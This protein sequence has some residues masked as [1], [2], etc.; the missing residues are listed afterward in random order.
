M[1]ATRWV[2]VVLLSRFEGR[3][4]VLLSRRVVLLS[5]SKLKKSLC[6]RHKYAVSVP[7]TRIL[8]YQRLTRS[9]QK[10]TDRSAARSWPASSLGLPSKQAE[11]SSYVSLSS[12]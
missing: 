2:K 4:V 11:V 1:N 7:S 3:E 10:F 5:R 9:Y 8:L 6:R 12:R